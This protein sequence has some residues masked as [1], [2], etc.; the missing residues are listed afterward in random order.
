MLT[1]TS[2]LITS[3]AEIRR[4]QL[5][6]MNEL[7]QG[8]KAESGRTWAPVLELQGTPGFFLD[9]TI[10]SVNV[11]WLEDMSGSCLTVR[12]EVV[13]TRSRSALDYHRGYRAG[14]SVLQEVGH[15]LP[16]LW[17]QSSGRDA[18]PAWIPPPS[19]TF[20]WKWN[21][22]I[23]KSNSEVALVHC[24]ANAIQ[25]G[26]LNLALMMPSCFVSHLP[27]NPFW[28]ARTDVSLLCTPIT[29]STAQR[30]GL[31]AATIAALIAVEC[32]PVKMCDLSSSQPTIEALS[33]ISGSQAQLSLWRSDGKSRNNADPTEAD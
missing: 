31:L 21:M 22:W 16:N 15:S 1:L 30:G 24:Y 7:S 4:F 9:L 17:I 29:H 33:F 23:L 32:A 6:D 5:P 13:Q 20:S 2:I 11:C 3:V 8:P 14:N 27:W 19:G 25:I 28:D 26:V 12:R 10:C 18:L